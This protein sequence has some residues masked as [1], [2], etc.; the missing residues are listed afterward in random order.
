MPCNEGMLAEAQSALA[1]T[2]ELAL[3]VLK[4]RR[5]FLQ[6]TEELEPVRAANK[7][8]MD[9]LDEPA[10]R[11]NAEGMTHIAELI[12][13]AVSIDDKCEALLVASRD[14]DGF[15]AAVAEYA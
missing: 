10:R 8:K 4:V 13:K 12:E 14:P 15:R 6:A 5:Q 9:Q 11:C 7:E 3:V 2:E 1:K